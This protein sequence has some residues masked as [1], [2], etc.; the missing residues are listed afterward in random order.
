[1]PKIAVVTGGSG[2]IGAAC[3]RALSAAGFCVVLL[4]LQNEEQAALL[5]AEA[6]AEGRTVQAMRCD[7]GDGQQ[8]DETFRQILSVWRHID[9]LV[10]CAGTAL[11]KLFQDTTDAEWQHLLNVHVMGAARSARAAL[12]AMLSR[13]S[14]CI[15]QVTSM[16][17]ETGA[18]CE[19]AYS[20]AKAALIGFTKALAKEVAP[21]GIRV[22][23]VSPGAVDT[24]MNRGVDMTELLSEIPLGRLAAPEE[25]AQAVLFLAS[26]SAAYITGEVLRVN[27]GLVI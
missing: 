7:V 22:N 27:G 12:P 23:A 8:V 15:I 18:S 21:S 9:V 19:V 24:G 17:G 25:V 1:M 26:P 5:C 14:G 13:G 10:N 20:A 2:G 4:Y 11:I 3:V 6:T 16:W